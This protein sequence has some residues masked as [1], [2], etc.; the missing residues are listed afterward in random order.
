MRTMPELLNVMLE[1]QGKFGDGLC[2]WAF[3]IYLNGLMRNDEYVSI[4]EYIKEHRPNK[5]NLH[6]WK[7]NELQ[8]RIDWI[9]E[10]L[11]S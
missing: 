7:R 10:Q 1:N 2:L 5:R 11:N 8:P 6:S 9:N 4:L 3:R